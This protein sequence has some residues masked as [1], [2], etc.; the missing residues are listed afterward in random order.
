MVFHVQNHKDKVLVISERYYSVYLRFANFSKIIKKWRW[1]ED[2]L[3]EFMS[4]FPQCIF[5]DLGDLLE[6]AAWAFHPLE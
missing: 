1:T 5:P 6:Q 3:Q 2:V 4:L